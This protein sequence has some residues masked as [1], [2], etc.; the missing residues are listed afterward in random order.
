MDEIKVLDVVALKEDLPEHGLRQ[1]EV[2]TV[3]E[4]WNDGAYEIEFSDDSGEAYAFAALP[5]NQL[6]KLHFQ[7]LDSIEPPPLHPEAHKFLDDGFRFFNN[8]DEIQAESK[9][10]SAIAIDARSRGAILNSILRSF[11][12]IHDWGA[13]I[14]ALRVLYHLDPGYAYGRNNL[15]I[16]YLN[17]GVEKAREGDTEQA[18]TLFSYAITLDITA[19][20]AA[21]VRENY[22]GVLTTL[23]IEAHKKSDYENTVPPMRLARM[24][25]PGDET[26]HNLGL[27][28]AYLALSHMDR[29]Q[30]EAAIPV[31]EE[32]EEAGLTLPELLNDYAIALVFENR[33]VEAELAF[34]RA[35]V[36]SPDNYLI[37]EN[38]TKLS[39]NDSR[40]TL[41]QEEL[42][43]QYIPIPTASYEYQL[44]A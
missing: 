21:K 37:K 16:T 32:A 40:D 12:T 42:K 10:R 39:R 36:L 35:L 2:G 38:L 33:G 29:G 1:G 41:I 30:Y 17:C 34:R 22:A 26:R 24:V 23:G 20:V 6:L 7:K 15:A 25:F 19:D 18:M 5:S 9:L 11:E 28:Y 13:R 27:A 4:R 43:V 44:A 14:H 8:G 31:F 3:V